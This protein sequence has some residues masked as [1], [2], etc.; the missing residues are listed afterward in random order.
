MKP[1]DQIEEIVIVGGGPV[2]NLS[3]VLS[4]F[5]GAKTTVY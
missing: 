2:G 5:L 4:G 3:A 1:G